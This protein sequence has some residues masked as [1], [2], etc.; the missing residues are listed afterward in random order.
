MVE[1]IQW[2]TNQMYVSN[3]SQYSEGEALLLISVS[4]SGFAVMFQVSEVH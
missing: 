2:S 3:A 4:H 1:D